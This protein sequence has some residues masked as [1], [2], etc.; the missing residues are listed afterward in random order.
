[1][2]R[3]M[4]NG[5]TFRSAGVGHPII[6]GATAWS[7]IDVSPDSTANPAHIHPLLAAE[8][9]PRHPQSSAAPRARR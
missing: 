5:Y 4:S 9:E 6:P 1:M 3:Q 8:E 2:S 7:V